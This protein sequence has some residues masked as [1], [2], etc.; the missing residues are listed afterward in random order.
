MQRAAILDSRFSGG[1]LGRK[2]RSISGEGLYQ[3]RHFS[4]NELD[5]LNPELRQRISLQEWQDRPR[6]GIPSIIVAQTFYQSSSPEDNAE[7]AKHRAPE[8]L[9]E[10]INNRQGIPRSTRSQA[11]A[12]RRL[13]L[14]FVAGVL[15]ESSKRIIGEN[16]LRRF[17]EFKRYHSGWDYGRGKPLSPRSVTVLNSFLEQLP[18]LAAREPSLFLTHQGNLSLGWEDEHG[19][20]VELE[21]FPNKV[22]YY[23]ESLN[24][25]GWVGLEALRQLIDKVKPTIS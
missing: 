21:F 18:E 6:K 10:L 7:E 12:S 3:E 23:I 19:N 1:I 8:S 22:E 24:E 14:R 2:S 13:F 15:S 16:G 20:V 25:E 17:E 4:F 5:L 9:S 11:Q